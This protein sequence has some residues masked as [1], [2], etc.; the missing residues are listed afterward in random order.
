MAT[1]F[2]IDVPASRRRN[3]EQDPSLQTVPDFVGEDPSVLRSQL[4]AAPLLA[5]ESAANDALTQYRLQA[6]EA[7]GDYSRLRGKATMPIARRCRTAATA[8]SA[9]CRLRRLSIDRSF[10]L[11]DRIAIRYGYQLI[12]IVVY[13]FLALAVALIRSATDHFGTVVTVILVIVGLLPGLLLIVWW[14]LHKIADRE[15]LVG[16]RT[17]PLCW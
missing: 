11:T 12:G 9:R 5:H 1:Y 17:S 2:T 3:Q 16:T 15:A 13:V 8:C 6:L 10:R 14:G 4:S 7:L